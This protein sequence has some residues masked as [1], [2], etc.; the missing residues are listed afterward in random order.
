M[1]QWIPSEYHDRILHIQQDITTMTAASLLQLIQQK[2][3]SA[4]WHKFVWCHGSPSCRTH[5]RADRGLSKHRDLSGKPLSASAKADDTALDSFINIML[6]IRE[7]SPHA[8]ISIENPVSPT[9]RLQPCIQR[10]RK[11]GWVWVTGS[12]CKSAD[13]SFDEGV[14]ARPLAYCGRP[15]TCIIFRGH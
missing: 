8:L 10:L 4:E 1:K 5:S 13:E 14:V 15:L 11:Q 3:P 6:T 7:Q 2:W 12:Y 9:F